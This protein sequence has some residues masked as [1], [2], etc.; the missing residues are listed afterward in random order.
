MSTAIPTPDEGAP[1]ER[2]PRSIHRRRTEAV[3]KPAAGYSREGTVSVKLGADRKERTDNA[4]AFAGPHVGITTLADL[5]REAVDAYV[6]TLEKEHNN[7][8]PFPAVP[9]KK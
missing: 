5:I 7:G 6:T 3:P 8:E 9:K 4:L 1:I 2:R